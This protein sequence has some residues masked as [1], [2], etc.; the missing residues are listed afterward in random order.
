MVI[1]K[2]IEAKKELENKIRD[3]LKEF[4]KKTHL[5]IE[6]ID[7]DERILYYGEG[8]CEIGGVKIDVKL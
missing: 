3:M 4:E 5:K 6:N 2:V 1:E 8:I 7:I